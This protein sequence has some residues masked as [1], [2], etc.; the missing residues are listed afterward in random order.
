MNSV[1]NCKE[2]IFVTPEQFASLFDVA[3]TENQDQLNG[4][5]VVRYLQRPHH[6]PI[7]QTFTHIRNVK[8]ISNQAIVDLSN[9][10][11][12]LFT[13]K[14]RTQMQKIKDWAIVAFIALASAIVLFS[15]MSSPFFFFAIAS[16]AAL[17]GILASPP[18]RKFIKEKIYGAFEAK[19]F[20]QVDLSQIEIK[21]DKRLNACLKRALGQT[22]KG[23]SSRQ[24]SQDTTY[25]Q[26]LN[27]IEHCR[28]CRLA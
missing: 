7:S 2:K 17:I 10:P 15:V 13:R 8:F 24:I 4:F 11:K 20:H 6:E 18:V 27:L 21:D 25:V 23:Q 3:Y 16:S 19:T 9:A 12:E 1:Q 22:N 5:C 14:P 26:L 28:S